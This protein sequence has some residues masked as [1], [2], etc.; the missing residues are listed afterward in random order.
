SPIS[1]RG[2]EVSSFSYPLFTLLI[3][4]HLKRKGQKNQFKLIE[5]LLI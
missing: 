2:W 5:L 4:R 1:G 3:V